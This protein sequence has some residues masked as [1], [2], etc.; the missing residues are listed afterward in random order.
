MLI[1]FSLN[2]ARREIGLKGEVGL[3]GLIKSGE[4]EI[5]YTK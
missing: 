2:L 1:R 4:I 3:E 5:K